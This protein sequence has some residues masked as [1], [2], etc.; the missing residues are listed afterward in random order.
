MHSQNGSAAPPIADHTTMRRAGRPVLRTEG[1]GRETRPTKR[2][3]RAGG[4]S[5]CR[6][7][8]V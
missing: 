3:Y 8:M 4:L 7:I 5:V 1:T 6:V 2:G